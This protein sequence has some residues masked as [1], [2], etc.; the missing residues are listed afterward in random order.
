MSY[1]IKTKS[2]SKKTLLCCHNSLHGKMIKDGKEKPKIIKFYD[3]TKGGTGIV[4]QLNDYYTTG[5]PV[6]GLCGSLSHA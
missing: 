5:N 3:F 2:K 4:D 1:T 6:N